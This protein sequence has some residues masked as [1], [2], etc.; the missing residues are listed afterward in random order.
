VRPIPANP[1]CIHRK[2]ARPRR[3]ADGVG[4]SVQIEPPE[5]ACH[6]AHRLLAGC[7][8]FHRRGR[9]A[10][11]SS[12]ISAASSMS[13]PA[14]DPR[15]RGALQFGQPFGAAMGKAQS[16]GRTRAP[17]RRSPRPPCAVQ[18]RIPSR[19]LQ[20]ATP[21][22]EADFAQIFLDQ[23]CS[24]VSQQAGYRCLHAVE[25]Q[26]HAPRP[27]L[28]AAMPPAARPE[29]LHRRR[30]R[31]RASSWSARSPAGNGNGRP[32]QRAIN[33]S[34]ASAL[35]FGIARCTVPVVVHRRAFRCD[36]RKIRRKSNFESPTTKG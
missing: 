23:P 3:R 20:P 24:I 34:Q 32:R 31:Q 12:I 29:R 17:R 15:Q 8:V 5:L 28:R 6:P 35:D 4:R 11:G 19:T 16:P 33:P 2:A 27:T 14:S 18:D 30:R 9:V 1:A 13:V 26:T 36:P 10:S 7:G 21:F 25:R 22:V